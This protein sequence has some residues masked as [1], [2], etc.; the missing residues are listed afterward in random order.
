MKI[1]K[2]DTVQVLSGKDRG[3]QG[4]VKMTLPK[5]SKVVVDGV[6]IVKR[7]KKEQKTADNKKPGIKLFEAPIH[8]SKVMVVD[9]KSG[10]TTR[11]GYEI[12]NG[13][14]VR[15]SRKTKKELS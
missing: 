4:V 10:K 6:N 2:G 14:K 13:K 5:I 15:I 11:V 9:T 1:R 8:A 7:H 3:K 12:K